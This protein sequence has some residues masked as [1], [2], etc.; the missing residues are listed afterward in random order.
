MAVQLP[1]G[2]I[3]IMQVIEYLRAFLIGR[4]GLSRHNILLIVSGAFGVFDK[5]IVTQAGGYAHTVGED[6]E[7]IVRLHRYLKENNMQRVITYIPDPVCWTEAP[8]TLAML[9]KQRSRWHQGLTDSLRQHRRLFFNPKYGK[10]GLVSFPY[11]VLVEFLGPF[12]EAFGYINIITG[13]FLGDMYV[14]FSFAL[15]L[16]SILYGSFLSM[17]AVLLEE[18]SLRKYPRISDLNRLVVYSLTETFWYRPLTVWYRLEGVWRFI[19]KKQGWGVMV[20]KG[21]SS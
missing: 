3:A 12:V 21:V 6:M 7:L 18:W 9:R 14:Y 13:F 5:N 15:L 1:Q 2:R 19:R 8:E 17:G 20:R 4:V 16:M 10:L 11:F